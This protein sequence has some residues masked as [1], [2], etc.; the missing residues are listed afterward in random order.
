MSLL[1]EL[2]L[3]LVVLAVY[4]L[5]ARPA[6]LW[7]GRKVYAWAG[8]ALDSLLDWEANAGPD[9]RKKPSAKARP[10]A[11]APSPKPGCTSAKS[12]ARRPVPART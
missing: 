12:K 4:E 2:M 5:A 1:I 10:K 8:D 11:P 7:C 6:V 3:W 9:R